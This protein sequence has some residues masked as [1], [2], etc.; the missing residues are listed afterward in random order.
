M[1]STILANLKLEN[2]DPNTDNIAV[3]IR[4]FTLKKKSDPFYDRYGEPYI[5]SLAIDANGVT[6]PAIEF[7]ILPFPNI[8][9]GQTVKFD[10]HGHLVYGPHN[11]GEFLVYSILY[12]ESDRDLR[13]FGEAVEA[14]VNDEATKMGIKTILS[15]TPNYALAATVLTQLTSIVA[16]RLK[17]NRDDELFRQNGTLLRDIVPPYDILR[18]Y[19]ENENDFIAP[20]VSIL[21]LISSNNL[22]KQCTKIMLK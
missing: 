9:K 3:V 22:G 13:D 1:T 14:I 5:L 15:A 21:P 20:V 8:K 17:A 6:N 4:E 2:F 7:N 12:M 18:T 19:S 11:P 10:G 16:K